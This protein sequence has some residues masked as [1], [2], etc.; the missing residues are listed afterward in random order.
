MKN[1]LIDV[2]TLG[3]D[4]NA[5]LLQIAGVVT[6]SE[7]SV[8]DMLASRFQIK[9]DARQQKDSGRTIDAATLKF[10]K[11]QP[12]EVRE[13]VILPSKQDKSM[14][15]AIDEFERIVKQQG[16]DPERN[17]NSMIFQRGSKDTDWL[18]NMWV[19]NHRPTTLLPWYKVFDIR[20]AFNVLGVSPKLNGYPDLYDIANLELKSKLDALDQLELAHNAMH[21]VGREVIML[22]HFGLI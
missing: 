14:N 1:L 9:L 18:T 5:V 16:F 10:W 22:R 3:V 4:S 8:D 13:Q 20:T 15:D 12:I 17:F 21:D 19:Q 6:D 7:L 2:E 11:E